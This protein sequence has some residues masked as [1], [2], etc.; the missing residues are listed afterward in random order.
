[1]NGEK[2]GAKQMQEFVTTAK[3]LANSAIKSSN[4]EVQSFV[5][6]FEDTLTPAFKKSLLNRIHKPFNVQAVDVAPTTTESP[7][8]T[9]D[10]TQNSVNWEDM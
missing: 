8:P 10:A 9:V 5:D 2:L 7:E 3:H 6:T 4:V 1:M